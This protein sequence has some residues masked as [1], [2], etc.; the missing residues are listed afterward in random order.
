MNRRILVTGGAS[1]L[2]KEICLALL[3]E[4]HEVVVLDQTP[5]RA[6]SGDWIR[7]VQDYW[8]VDLSDLGS[9]QGIVDQRIRHGKTGIQV[10]V[11]NASPRIFKH[12]K[13][14]SGREIIDFINASLAGH[15][16][17]INALLPSML[18][19]RFGRIVVIGSGSGVRGY[20][21][22]SLYCAMKAAFTALHESLDKELGSYRRNVTVTTISPGS[23][24]DSLG[25]PLKH[26]RRIVDQTVLYVR[27]AI[28][29]QQSRLRYAAETKSLIRFAIQYLRKLFGVFS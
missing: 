10:V 17:L 19:S 1:G 27:E 16:L 25:R 23:F 12:F 21:S 22:G 6:V 7:Q 5:R 13:D 28:D 20:S 3:H 15:L 11:A 26:H 14:F 29:S 8:E 2:G 18:E 9:L 24:S 4:G